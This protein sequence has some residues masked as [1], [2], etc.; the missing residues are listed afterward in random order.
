[1]FIKAIIEC[2]WCKILEYRN[3]FTNK[4]ANL[5]AS[6]HRVFKFVE[7]FMHFWT[8]L[9]CKVRGD[10]TVVRGKYKFENLRTHYC[11]LWQD[12]HLHEKQ[13][14]PM[15]IVASYWKI[16]ETW[17]HAELLIVRC[18]SFVHNLSKKAKSHYLI[19]LLPAFTLSSIFIL[20]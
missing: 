19:G 13:S 17:F 7:V 5:L 10:I 18:I 12:A 6:Q 20:S 15:V 4:R 11:E 14:G 2:M 3:F 1:M 8:D 16:N 9:P